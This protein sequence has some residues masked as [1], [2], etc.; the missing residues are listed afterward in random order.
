LIEKDGY[1]TKRD[2]FSTFGKVPPRRQLKKENDIALPYEA[3]LDKI[4]I[5]AAIVVENI[6]YDLNR[7]NIRPDAAAELD[8]I[9]T[10]LNDN[11]NITIELSSHTDSRGDDKLNQRLSQLR[12][13]SATL[14]IES[15]GIADN[16]IFGKGYGK[17]RPI[18][19]NATTEEEHQKNR[20]TEFKVTKIEGQIPAKPKSEAKKPKK[21]KGKK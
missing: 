1:F 11:P 20:R 5:Q 18:I 10:M 19:A 6:Y 3:G 8:K 9:V 16:R 21:A 7:A 14:Y 4:K 2:A 17:T 13:D 12:A 15:K